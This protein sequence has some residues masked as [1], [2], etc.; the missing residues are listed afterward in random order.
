MTDLNKTR[1]NWFQIRP[2]LK[3]QGLSR[4]PPETPISGGTYKPYPLAVVWAR[5]IS[6]NLRK[7]Y[8]QRKR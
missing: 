4:G 2:F 6:K 5:K 8:S 3:Q 1:Q 7:R